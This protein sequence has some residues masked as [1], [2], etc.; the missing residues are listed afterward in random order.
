MSAFLHCTLTIVLLLFALRLRR[1][2]RNM[3][4]MGSLAA[5]YLTELLKGD[6]FGCVLADPLWRFTNRTG[7]V[8][9]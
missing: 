9:P 7:K 8:A 1:K 5:Q 3:L 4:D 6:R 2:N